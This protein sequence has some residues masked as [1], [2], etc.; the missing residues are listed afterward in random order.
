MN[1][2]GFEGLGRINDEAYNMMGCIAGKR[3]MGNPFYEGPVI[4]AGMDNVVMGDQLQK[5]KNKRE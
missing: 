5:I 4:S 2:Y 1:K 3:R